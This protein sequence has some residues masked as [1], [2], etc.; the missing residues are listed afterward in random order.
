MELYNLVGGRSRLR[1]LANDGSSG[2]GS[3]SLRASWPSGQEG[4]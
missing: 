4:S 2:D 1:D 3:L